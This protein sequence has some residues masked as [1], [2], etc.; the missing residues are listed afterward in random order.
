MSQISSLF[1]WRQR[2]KVN[3][4]KIIL[5]KTRILLGPLKSKS[6]TVQNLCDIWTKHSFLPKMSKTDIVDFPLLLIN[7]LN[8]C[9][10]DCATVAG[11]WKIRPLFWLHYHCGKWEG[12]ALKHLVNHTDWW[13][14]SLQLT[15]LNWFI[16]SIIERLCSVFVLFSLCNVCRLGVFAIRPRQTLFSLYN[17]SPCLST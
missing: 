10:F 15:I 8:V 4:S 5:F 16:I 12:W 6:T 11:S 9:P 3:V 7:V 2:T 13:L 14:F 1:S 17:K